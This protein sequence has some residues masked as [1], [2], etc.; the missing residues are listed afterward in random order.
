MQSDMRRAT[1]IAHRIADTKANRKKY[2]RLIDHNFNLVPVSNLEVNSSFNIGMND[3]KSLILILLIK[4]RGNA[5]IKAER[6][7]EIIGGEK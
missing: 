5:I 2:G 4:N 6:I 3:I 1:Q 7:T